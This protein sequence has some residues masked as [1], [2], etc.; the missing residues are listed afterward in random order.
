VRY[1]T[2]KRQDCRF[3]SFA[4]RNL[5]RCSH[6]TSRCHRHRPGRGIWDRPVDGKQSKAKT[7]T[8]G[9]CPVKSRTR[10]IVSQRRV[11]RRAAGS[12]G[13]CSSSAGSRSVPGTDCEA[14]STWAYF[15]I[16]H[17]HISR[18]G[19]HTLSGN[20]HFSVSC[21][22]GMFE[23][24]PSNNLCTWSKFVIRCAAVPVPSS[25]SHRQ[26][27]RSHAFLISLTFLLHILERC[28]EIR[29][30]A[31][32]CVALLCLLLHR[33]WWALYVQFDTWW[34]LRLWCRRLWSRGEW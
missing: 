9:T 18:Q 22:C 21:G 1:L 32:E 8:A 10:K 24:P 17:A 6:S 29:E 7:L 20:T 4:A 27:E 25:T 12:S 14:H 16:A 30:R 33:R 11:A 2:W 23:Y 15:P 19:A 26:H 5:S 34:E 31:W 3:S 28:Y 13:S